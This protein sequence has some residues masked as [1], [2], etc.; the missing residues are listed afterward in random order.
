VRLHSQT[1][2]T[3]RVGQPCGGFG[4]EAD[5]S[6]A[7]RKAYHV[8]SA[9]RNECFTDCCD[10]SDGGGGTKPR[11]PLTSRL[12]H[13]T[14]NRWPVPKLCAGCAIGTTPWAWCTRWTGEGNARRAE[15]TRTHAHTHTYT[16]A[17]T[18]AY[19]HART[20]TR[21]HARV[22]IYKHQVRLGLRM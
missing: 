15:I 14:T 22:Y 10:R 4:L 19:T 1:V 21:A 11:K 8:R 17:H 2:T 16:R 9:D 5:G 20:H 7:C 13:E 6:P 12:I 3:C 18:R